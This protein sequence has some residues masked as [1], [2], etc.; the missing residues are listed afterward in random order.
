MRIKHTCL[1]LKLRRKSRPKLIK[2]GMRW[3]GVCELKVIFVIT[4]RH[5]NRKKS[6]D[7]LLDASKKVDLEVSAER[8]KYVMF[9]NHNAGPNHNIKI[10]NKSLKYVGNL[11]YFKTI[12]TDQSRIHKL[13]PGNARYN[14]VNGCKPSF[15]CCFVW[16]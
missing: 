15:I 3:M 4:S 16:V 1:T 10:A 2:M 12:I 11:R 9:H 7:S 6:T 13:N 5:I 8:T 14:S